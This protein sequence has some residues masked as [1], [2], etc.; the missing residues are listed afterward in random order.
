MTRESLD[1]LYKIN[2]AKK[3]N[4]IV[5]SETERLALTAEL[6]ELLSNIKDPYLASVLRMRY[7]DAM[8]WEAAAKEFVNAGPDALR[9]MCSRAISKLQTF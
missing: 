7:I 8:T 9:K 2:S 5:G 3:R 1:R 4:I 6:E